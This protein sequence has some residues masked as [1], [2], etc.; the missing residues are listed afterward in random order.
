MYNVHTHNFDILIQFKSKNRSVLWIRIH[1]NPDPEADPSFQ[2]NPDDP[3]F[4]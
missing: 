1:L 3:G 2:V 4:W